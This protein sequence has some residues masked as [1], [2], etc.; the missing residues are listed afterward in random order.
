M[1]AGVA[2]VLVGAGCHGRPSAGAESRRPAA[3]AGQRGLGEGVL[4]GTV[5]PTLEAASESARG[6]TEAEMAQAP[7][8]QHLIQCQGE[9]KNLHSQ[10]GVVMLGLGSRDLTLTTIAPRSS[11]MLRGE[12]WQCERTNE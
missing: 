8:P 4:S 1:E 3:S 7:R 9:P 6:L 12:R 5:V 10:Q 11:S 2:C